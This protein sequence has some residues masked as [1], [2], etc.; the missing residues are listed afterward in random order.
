MIPAIETLPSYEETRNHL[1]NYLKDYKTHINN[2]DNYNDLVEELEVY[3]IHDHEKS[4]IYTLYYPEA[5]KFM[6]LEE[7]KLKEVLEA[8]MYIQSE[9][10]GEY[11]EFIYEVFLNTEPDI[12]YIELSNWYYYS[13]C[14][15]IVY[16]TNFLKEF[17]EDNFNLTEETDN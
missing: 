16:S 8:T 13:L 9:M 12:D 17:I 11:K 1:L 7:G 3:L 5:I 4:F 15:Y 14:W 10:T 6:Q 2:K